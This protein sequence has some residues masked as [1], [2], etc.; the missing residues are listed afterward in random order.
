MIVVA[1]F[2][3]TKEGKGDEFVR[4]FS[5]LG[6]KVRKDP[7]TIA[8]VLHRGTKDPDSFFF[9]EKY[10]SPETLKFHTST[11]HFKEFFQTCG[12]IMVGR[13]EITQY[14]EVE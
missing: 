1:A 11:P 3:K 7:G 10:D 5:K 2:I 6:P 9:Y 4:E 14:Q 13:P 12:P 8:Y